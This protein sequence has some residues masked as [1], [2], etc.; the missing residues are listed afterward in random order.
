[1]EEHKSM[2]GDNIMHSD[3]VSKE[4]QYREQHKLSFWELFTKLK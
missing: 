1:M 3:K 2:N 4:I